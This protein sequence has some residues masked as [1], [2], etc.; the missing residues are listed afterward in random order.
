MKAEITVTWD[1]G[2][3]DEVK[4]FLLSLPKQNGKKES[5]SISNGRRNEA[6]SKCN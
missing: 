4:K 2:E 3:F 1:Q 5:Q 6:T